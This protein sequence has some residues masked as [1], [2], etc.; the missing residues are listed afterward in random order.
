MP[1]VFMHF[2]ENEIGFCLDE[3]LDRGYNIAMKQS[4]YCVLYSS[5]GKVDHKIRRKQI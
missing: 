2:Y 4:F 3:V 1:G 5:E